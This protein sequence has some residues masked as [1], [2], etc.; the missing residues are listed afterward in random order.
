LAEEEEEEKMVK[1]PHIRRWFPGLIIRILFLCETFSG[2]EEIVDLSRLLRPPPFV[3]YVCGHYCA[4]F[5]P[6][7]W[8][9]PN[10]AETPA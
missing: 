5:T 6:S 3:N 9:G 4:A 8:E 2:G 7:C 1:E 10:N